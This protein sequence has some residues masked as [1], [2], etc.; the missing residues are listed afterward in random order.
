MKESFIDGGRAIVANDQTA[1]VSEP[2]KGALHFPTAPIAAQHSTVL[3]ARLA[4]IP[5]MRRDQFD[6]ACRQ[7]LAQRIA[8]VG[9]IGNHTLGFL[10]WPSTALSPA[11][12]NRRQ[13]F[14]R[15]PDFVGRC[16]VKLLSQ[17]N[18][19]AV[20]HH[21]PLRA[22]APLGFSD[23][24]APFFAGAK[25]PSRNDSL[26][27][28]CS[29]WFSSA[30]NARQMVSQIPCS[31]QSRSRRQHVAGEGNSSGKSC[32]RAP[33]RKIHRIPSSTLRSLAGGRPPCGRRGRFGSKGPIFSHWASVS[34]R[35]Y[36]AIGPPLA[37]LPEFISRFRQT[38][39]QPFSTLYPVL[40]QVLGK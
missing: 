10:T 24:R 36:R 18:T 37:L 20:D 32:Q 35:P 19:L 38:N 2:S 23:F 17:R 39:H 31:S 3:G 13:R 12:T 30:R 6:P 8:V 26:Q 28:S 21:H 1:K 22:L 29:R 27:S 25:L 33:L 34:R 40:K 14:F 16:R 11:H 7:P 15:E 9:A 4:A 5:T